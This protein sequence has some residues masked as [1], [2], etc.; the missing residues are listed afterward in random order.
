[1]SDRDGTKTMPGRG[2][3]L[4][5][6]LLLT[7]V[8]SVHSLSGRLH[9]VFS[10]P[11][12]GIVFCLCSSGQEPL[13]SPRFPEPSLSLFSLGCCGYVV[14]SSSVSREKVALDCDIVALL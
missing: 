2:S 12:F 6:C 3:K 13:G 8:N 14:D 11:L 1:M 10:W 7:R 4:D 9:V 5:A